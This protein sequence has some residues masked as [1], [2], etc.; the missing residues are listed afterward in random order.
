[1]GS[2]PVRTAVTTMRV[3][4]FLAPR[5]ADRLPRLPDSLRRHGAG[6]DKNGIGQPGLAASAF[7]TS[8]S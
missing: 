1:M 8:D 7:M 6:V 3:E 4:G 5:P 2:K